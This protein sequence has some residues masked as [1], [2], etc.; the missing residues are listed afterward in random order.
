MT[1]P[2]CNETKQKERRLITNDLVL[3]KSCN[4]Y[5]SRTTETTLTL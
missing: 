2:T 5:D 3:Q 4:I 1:F